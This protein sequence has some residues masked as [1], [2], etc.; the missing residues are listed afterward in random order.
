[1][2]AN[3]H[4]RIHLKRR[5]T[6]SKL[7]VKENVERT[8]RNVDILGRRTSMRLE[9]AF[10]EMGREIVSGYRFGN[11]SNLFS[12]A[13][14]ENFGASMSSAVRCYLLGKC[15]DISHLDNIC[16]RIRRNLMVNG[17]RTS[18]SMEIAYW[19]GLSCVC[20]DEERSLDEV[21][22][23]LIALSSATSMASS[24]RVGVLLW[25]KENSSRPLFVA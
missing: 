24:M 16:L 4:D 3:D 11:I 17:R 6:L 7:M 14:R 19:E 2:S 13:V 10:W 12:Q 21:F 15:I 1:M 23:D 20:R 22:N 8:V 25:A 9:K 18:V 5:P